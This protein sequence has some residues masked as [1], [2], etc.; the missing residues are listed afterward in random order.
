MRI[1]IISRHAPDPEGTP[2]ERR[3]HRR[4]IEFATLNVELL[5]LTRYRPDDLE[6]EPVVLP[7]NIDL[8]RPFT[9]GTANEWVRALP[10]V[11]GFRPDSLHVIDDHLSPT[12]PPWLS[13][14]SAERFVPALKSLTRLKRVVVSSHDEERKVLWPGC[15]VETR[16][17]NEHSS[18]QKPHAWHPAECRHVL[19]AGTTEQRRNWLDDL[20][21]LLTAADA[22]EVE[23][24]FYFECDRTMLTRSERERLAGIERR[25]NSRGQARGTKIHLGAIDENTPLDAVIV[26]GAPGTERD[27]RWTWLPKI[28]TELEVQTRPADATFIVVPDAGWSEFA[29]HV[30]LNIETLT[31]TWN[32]IGNSPQ[33]TGTDRLTNELSRLHFSALDER[34][35]TI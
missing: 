24:H 17:L 14:I 4:L 16:W 21:R 9:H 30:G 19:L 33:F 13:W 29:V 18:E 10:L 7:K 22:Q 15:I 34:K 31:A 2:L 12:S 8:R 25:Q 3:L 1:A 20:E 6:R 23:V 26:A 5:L 35:V 32:N 28:A 11:M 27:L